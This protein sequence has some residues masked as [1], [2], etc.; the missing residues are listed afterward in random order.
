MPSEQP[1][2]GKLV[3]IHL[4]DIHLFHDEINGSQDIDADIRKKLAADIKEQLKQIG[5]NADGILVSGDISFASAESEFSAAYAW[6]QDLAAVAG[7]KHNRIWMIPGNHDA[8]WAAMSPVLLDVHEAIRA[9]NQADRLRERLNDAST[10]MSLLGPFQRYNVLARKFACA[11]EPSATFW[12]SDELILNDGSVLRIRGLNSALVSDRRD[13]ALGKPAQVMG[14][15]QVQLS[16]DDDGVAYLTMSHHPPDYFF[17]KKLVEDHL[18]SRAR[19]QLYGHEHTHRA[20]KHKNSVLVFAGALHPDR[21]EEGWEPR[22]NLLALEVHSEAGKR[23][24]HV[25]LYP[26]VWHETAKFVAQR[27]D[28]ERYGCSSFMTMTTTNPV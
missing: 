21:G 28:Q 9:T 6:L 10:A 19:V 14:H 5:R 2:P 16:D 26:R 11:T 4:S 25:E 17:D 22:Y 15:K 1:T 24:L 18:H 27:D 12:E 13:N 20:Y 3:L 23:T 8:A 7:C